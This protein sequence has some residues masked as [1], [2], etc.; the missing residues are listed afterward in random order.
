MARSPTSEKTFFPLRGV[1]Y[2]DKSSY[3][4]NI[5]FLS[6]KQ[7]A[8][9]RSDLRLTSVKLQKRRR[10]ARPLSRLPFAAAFLCASVFTGFQKG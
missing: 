5:I 8:R 2:R 3:F 10:P 7:V 1:S 9:E 4:K 6:K